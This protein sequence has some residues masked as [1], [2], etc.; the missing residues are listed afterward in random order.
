[1]IASSV[2]R[3]PLP[4]SHRRDRVTFRLEKLLAALE[5]AAAMRQQEWQHLL[6]AAP[7]PILP[8]LRA[9]PKMQR[10]HKAPRLAALK[11]DV[12]TASFYFLYR[13][14]NSFIRGGRRRISFYKT[15]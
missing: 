15:S 14:G 5:G 10:H 6:R 8:E 12:T 9:A 7:L 1:M 13:D 3:F 4:Y 2:S 11:A